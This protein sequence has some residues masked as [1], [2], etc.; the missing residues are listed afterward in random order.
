MKELL[1]GIK[2]EVEGFREGTVK[3]K[4]QVVEGTDPNGEDSFGG[5]PRTEN[6]RMQWTDEQDVVTKITGME[7]KN[8]K[9]TLSHLFIHNFKKN[10]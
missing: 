8:S 6:G 5:N 10:Y 2:G 4:D 7:N 3:L 1:P 9:I